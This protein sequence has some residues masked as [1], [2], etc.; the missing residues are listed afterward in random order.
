VTETDRIA[1]A[2]QEME[3]R[4]GD[5]WSLA[6]SGNRA[7]LAERRRRFKRLLE[8]AGLAPVGER[9]V[10]EVGSGTGT[11]LAWLLEL[12]ARPSNLF[13]VDLL[14]D[15]VAR[16][17]RSYPELDFRVGQPVHVSVAPNKCIGLPS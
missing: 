6:N 17:K 7:M 11:E 15:R 14:A 12:G 13:G 1:R 10:I 9:R 3:A 4:A 2:Y 5:R 8:E 16:A